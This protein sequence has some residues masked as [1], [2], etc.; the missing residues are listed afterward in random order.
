MEFV[1]Q[2]EISYSGQIRQGK[3]TQISQ[4]FDKLEKEPAIIQLINF[5]YIAM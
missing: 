3:Q 2:S 1:A 4:K 5:K